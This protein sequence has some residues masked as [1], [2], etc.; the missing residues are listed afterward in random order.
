MPPVILSVAKNLVSGRV[1][2]ETL[3]CARSDKYVKKAQSSRR[4]SGGTA[5]T[6]HT[7]FAEQ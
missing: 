4:Y 3:R 5:S 1:Y 7:P 6:N 2:D